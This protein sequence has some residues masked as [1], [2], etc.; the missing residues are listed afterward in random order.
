[1]TT[2]ARQAAVTTSVHPC[3]TL[4]GK[5]SLMQERPGDVT[6]LLQRLAEGDPAVEQQLYDLIYLD[7][8]KCARSVRRRFRKIPDIQTTQL[9]GGVYSRLAEV[10]TDQDWR[11]RQQF[12]AFFARSMQRY[13]LEYVRKWYPIDVELIPLEGL[14]GAPAAFPPSFHE[15]ILLDEWLE[16]LEAVDPGWATVVRMKCFLGFT[17]QEIA[18]S[19]TIP[20]STVRKWWL[21]ARKWLF[22]R[23]RGGNAQGAGR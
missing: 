3:G 17:D 11:D 13:M 23:M 15:V 21:M 4:R 10:I 19:M 9:V 6:T 20:L 12:Y 22:E 18:D 2:P 8:K 16:K 1:M 7:L 14:D 5:S